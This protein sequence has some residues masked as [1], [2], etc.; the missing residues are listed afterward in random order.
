[1]ASKKFNGE[2]FTA[3]LYNTESKGW[4]EAYGYLGSFYQSYAAARFEVNFCMNNWPEKYTAW[5][6]ERIELDDGFQVQ[7]PRVVV[8][9]HSKDAPIWS[10]SEDEQP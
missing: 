4:C 3:V 10:L 2:K 5:A 6:I 1:M 9:A 7:S 8:L